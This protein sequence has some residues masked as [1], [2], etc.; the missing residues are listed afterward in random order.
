MEGRRIYVKHPSYLKNELNHSGIKGMHW[1]ER[2][3]QYEDGSLTPLG[4]IRYGVGQV[5]VKRAEQAAAKAKA[6]AEQ[7]TEREKRKYQNKDGT[8]KLRGKL[9]YKTTDKYALLSD[10]EIRQQT[11]RLQLKKNLEDMKRQTSS[12]ERLKSKIGNTLE[13][14]T[15]S[16]IR[17]MGE[18]LV[19]NFVDKSVSKILGTDKENVERARKFAETVKDMSTKEM[20][21]RKTRAEAENKLYKELYGT[22][23]P[24]E[25]NRTD[26]TE[27]DKAGVKR[28]E[29]AD[30]NNANQPSKSS[31]KKKEGK[32]SSEKKPESFKPKEEAVKSSEKKSEEKKEGVKVTRTNTSSNPKI[33]SDTKRILDSFEKQPT[34]ENKS[35]VVNKDK[36]IVKVSRD[37][38]K[39]LSSLGSNK[40][41]SEE[42]A[43]ILTSYDKD[44]K[45][46]KKG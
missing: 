29:E 36:K 33:S 43:K 11:N 37:T 31:E 23:L 42:T 25:Y 18:K 4:R 32:Q 6:K 3:Y 45:K 8:L 17:R 46:K 26:L 21:S 39:V 27:K 41:V 20:N 1:G 5:R 13:D 22:D 12:V 24:K 9:H 19:N 44:D 28:A 40:E 14:V 2:L 15:V 10:D 35:Y 7:E 16:G 30:Q 34:K 38:A